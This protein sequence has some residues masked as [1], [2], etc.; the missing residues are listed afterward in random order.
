MPRFDGTGPGGQGPM[1][2]HGQGYCAIKFPA[3]GQAPYG[4]VGWQGTPVRWGALGARFARWLRPATR[5]GRASPGGRGRG[6]GRGRGF[7]R[8]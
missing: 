3:S 2:G 7:G 1:T 4:Y 6:A 8:R 5:L